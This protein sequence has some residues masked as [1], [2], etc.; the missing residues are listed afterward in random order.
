MILLIA[1]LFIIIQFRPT[2]R[3][4]VFIQMTGLRRAKKLSK[5]ID[6]LSNRIKFMF[7][8]K[9]NFKHKLQGLVQ[10]TG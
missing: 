1:Q 4:G 9:R 5:C 7:Y 10:K 6:L 2:K 8:F 3:S